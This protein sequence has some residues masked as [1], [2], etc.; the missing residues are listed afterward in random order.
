MQKGKGAA[1]METANRAKLG[2]EAK[3]DKRL[4]DTGAE[5][6]SK[7]GYVFHCLVCHGTL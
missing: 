6:K 1:D 5:T 2:R 3:R 7:T 4:K